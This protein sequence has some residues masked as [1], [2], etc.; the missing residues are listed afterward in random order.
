MPLLWENSCFEDGSQ[1]QAHQQAIT[2]VPNQG[3]YPCVSPEVHTQQLTDEVHSTRELQHATYL[4]WEESNHWPR[5]FGIKAQ[6]TGPIVGQN[7]QLNS[8]HKAVDTRG[9]EP[10]LLMITG[11][12]GLVSAGLSLLLSLTARCCSVQYL[13]HSSVCL[14]SP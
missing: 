4:S 2:P 6:L 7:N 8:L 13:L 1:L 10:L 11:S 5:F 14:M 3:V 12:P 9:L